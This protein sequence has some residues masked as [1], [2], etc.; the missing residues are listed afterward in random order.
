MHFAWYSVLEWR[1]PC[2]HCSAD[3]GEETQGEG[4]AS[5]YFSISI[6]FLLPLP[7]KELLWTVG[8]ISGR[9]TDLLYSQFTVFTIHWLL[10]SAEICFLH[11]RDF[12]L[13]IWSIKLGKDRL[14]QWYM[15]YSVYTWEMRQKFIPYF[16]L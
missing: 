4:V 11:T 3:P 8:V 9:R 2:A 7:H 13:K 6:F 15:S 14:T 5:P 16:W 12:R 10:E 1:L